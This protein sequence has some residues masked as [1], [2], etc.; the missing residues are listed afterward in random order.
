MNENEVV[1]FNKR[2]A[3]FLKSQLWMI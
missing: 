2:V 1:S 3:G